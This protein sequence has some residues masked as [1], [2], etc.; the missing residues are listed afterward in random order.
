MADTILR[1]F[2]TFLGVVPP[3]RLEARKLSAETADERCTAII[4]TV[5]RSLLART[6]K[7]Q[8]EGGG[9]LE[10]EVSNGLLGRVLAAEPGSILEGPD[11]PLAMSPDKANDP[12]QASKAMVQVI[13][14]FCATD[15]A[16]TVSER[17]PDD[18][19]VASHSGISADELR[20][21]LNDLL[22]HQNAGDLV[23]D[24]S[25]PA[26]A[27]AV[28]D[29]DSSADG[30]ASDNAADSSVAPTA[31]SAASVDAP[32]TVDSPTPKASETGET[33]G[34]ETGPPTT[35]RSVGR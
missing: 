15:G 11:A 10:L 27:V 22:A 25:N 29:P 21:R 30:N 31:V 17:R 6:L 5:G 33:A 19:Q 2:Q 7:F 18:D 16:L 23:D 1:M 9:H 34:E 14:S 32:D 20:R 13:R 3:S 28:T 12:D 26:T 35:S 4:D 8:I 24:G